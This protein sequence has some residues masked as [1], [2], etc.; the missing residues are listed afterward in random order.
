[1]L[2]KNLNRLNGQHESLLGMF[3]RSE[4]LVKTGEIFGTLDKLKERLQ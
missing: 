4:Q 3:E 1:M 2:E